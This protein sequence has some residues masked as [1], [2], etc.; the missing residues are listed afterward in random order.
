MV[1]HLIPLHT[2]Y[3]SP[4]PSSRTSAPDARA[5]WVGCPLEVS[6]AGSPATSALSS[7]FFQE[8]QQWRA[9]DQHAVLTTSSHHSGGHESGIVGSALATEGWL[10]D[11]D[12]EQDSKAE[13]LRG[14]QRNDGFLL[15]MNN[16]F[17]RDSV[18]VISQLS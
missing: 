3:P 14:P 4:H 7:R 9:G 12:H 17:P 13:V 5:K 6:W 1:T 15:V 8:T 10:W 11:R 18:S 16:F 2:V